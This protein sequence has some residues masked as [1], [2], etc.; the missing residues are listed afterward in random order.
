MIN[1]A[2]EQLFKVEFEI[3]FFKLGLG[4]NSLY[5]GFKFYYK[6]LRTINFDAHIIL[7]LTLKS[8]SIL[9]NSKLLANIIVNLVNLRKILITFE[10]DVF[11][12]IINYS[13]TNS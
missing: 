3:F 1:P 4:M 2:F 7:F 12:I 8:I 10:Y 5:M 9:S 13:L 11:A 6:I